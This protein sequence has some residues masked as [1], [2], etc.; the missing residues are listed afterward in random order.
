M[1]AMIVNLSFSQQLVRK[2]AEDNMTSAVTIVRKQPAVFDEATGM[3]SSGA[4][5]VI[6]TGKGR[7]YPATGPVRYALGDESQRFSGTSLSIPVETNDIPAVDDVVLVTA[8]PSDP[9]MVGR[10]FAVVDVESGGM[11]VAVR[12]MQLVGVQESPQWPV[13]SQLD[14]AGGAASAAGNNADFVGTP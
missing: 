9:A 12:R 3:L 5:T 8:C 13:V 6:Y 14:T 7:L 11:L 2:Y 1:S 10:F 4:P